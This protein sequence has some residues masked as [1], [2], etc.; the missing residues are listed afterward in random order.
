MRDTRYCWNVLWSEKVRSRE[1]G[2]TLH[3]H[4]VCRDAWYSSQLTLWWIWIW[5][6]RGN[7]CLL[8]INDD[9]VNINLL[10]AIKDH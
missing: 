8:N 10:D 2:L 1:D 3:D 5:I 6:C 9:D 4:S 7:N